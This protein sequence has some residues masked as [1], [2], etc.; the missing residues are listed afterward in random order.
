M[1]TTEHTTPSP[2]AVDSGASASASFRAGSASGFGSAG[3]STARV[4][5]LARAVLAAVHGVIREHK[6]TYPEFQAAKKWL[7]DL[8]DGGEWPLFLDVFV[9]HAVEE[10]A[11]E[12]QAGTTGT[13]LGPYYLPDQVRLPAVAALPARPD[14]PGSSW[15]FQ[16]QVRDLDGNPLAGAELDVWQN[17]ADGFYSGFAPHLPEGNLRG[18][19]VTDEQGRFAISTILP[20][21][22]QVPTDGPTGE[23]IEA[24]GWHPWRPAHLHLLVRADGHRTITTQLYFTGAQYIDDDVARAT[25]PELIL[26][27]QQLADGS[28]RSEYDFVLEPV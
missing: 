27:P 9:E 28:F 4:D 13:I 6:V 18:V 1:T 3:S 5:T 24:A 25:K 20:A 17:S 11:A 7:M 8:G 23:L 26:D 10:V 12:T 22:Y 15:L 16:G 19:V 14:E 2:S 21:P